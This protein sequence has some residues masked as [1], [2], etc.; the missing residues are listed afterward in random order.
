M[1]NRRKRYKDMEKFRKTRNAQRKRY[2]DKT[3]IYPP[4]RWTAEQ[5]EKV[6]EHSITDSELSKIIGHSVRAIQH[7]R[8]RLKRQL[9]KN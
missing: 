7:R 5:D 6:L 2:Y 3:S 1:P 4:S 9:K 8:S